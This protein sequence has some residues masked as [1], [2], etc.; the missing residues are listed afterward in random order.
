MIYFLFPTILKCYFLCLQHIS[1]VFSL[2]LKYPHK[3]PQNMCKRIAII[4]ETEVIFFRLTGIEA[5]IIESV[6]FIKQ[7]WRYFFLQA[8][9][10]FWSNNIWLYHNCLCKD[11]NFNLLT[12]VNP[13][14]NIITISVFLQ[15]VQWRRSCC[16]RNAIRKHVY[17]PTVTFD[18]RKK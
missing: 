17:L 18:A 14:H 2:P 6:I 10:S 11:E 16:H 13:Y 4:S 7:C 1:G 12:I 5:E 15:K 9:V 8:G 3:N